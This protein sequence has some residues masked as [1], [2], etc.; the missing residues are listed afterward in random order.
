MKC[1]DNLKYKSQNKEN[2]IYTNNTMGL[3]KRVSLNMEKL[4][5]DFF[6]IMCTVL[7]NRIP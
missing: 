2:L 1:N 6:T 5:C 4:G 7:L 3:I